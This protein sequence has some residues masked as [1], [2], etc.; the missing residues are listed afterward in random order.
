MT[1]RILLHLL[2]AIYFISFYSV[3]FHFFVS[4]ILFLVYSTIIAILGAIAALSAAGVAR[5]LSF[6]AFFVVQSQYLP[7]VTVW[8]SSQAV[9]PVTFVIIA[10]LI[11][12]LTTQTISKP[13]RESLWV[14]IPKSNKYRSK[15]IVDVLAHRIGTS[16]AAFLANV[17]IL[18]ALNTVLIKHKLFN[19]LHH[20][21]TYNGINENTEFEGIVGQDHIVWGLIVTVALCCFGVCL[22]RAY[23]GEKIKSE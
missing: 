22:G 10:D 15:I 14:L 9:I 6:V 18:S 19:K 20:M 17:P 21:M 2:F 5:F 16:L 23:N 4:F 1:L 8:Y 13:V 7:S 11:C 12:R 3:S